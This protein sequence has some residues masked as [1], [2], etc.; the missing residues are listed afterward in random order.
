VP[1]KRGDWAWARATDGAL[2]LDRHELW[3][4]PDF[5]PEGRSLPAQMLKPAQ[6]SATVPGMSAPRPRPRPRAHRHKDRAVRR[7]RRVAIL[8][9]LA[10]VLV[11][12][13]LLTAFGGGSSS[14]V[15]TAPANA[16]RLVPAGTPTPQVVAIYGNLRL[17]LPIAQ[18]SVTA[19]G[20]HGG[21]GGAVAL[22]PVGTQANQGVF[23]RLMHKLFGGDSGTLRWYQLPGGRGPSTSALDVGAAP[24]TDVYAPADG[25]VVGVTDLILNGRP[26]GQ[27]IELQP[28]GAPS[29]VV[30]VTRLARDPALVVGSAVSAGKSRL[31]SLL[32]FSAVERQTLARFTQDSGNHVAIEV[33]P[34][35]TLAIP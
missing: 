2:A 10:S 4:E 30:S 33:H 29:V 23:A 18:S 26:Y 32:D 15:Q 22:A 12:T 24:G 7:A 5:A 27:R 19:V 20:Y 35:A 1:L 17:Q 6:T 14:A 28:T 13:L 34:A 11:P 8:V 9:L 25:T 16:S 3:Q 21:S 31:G